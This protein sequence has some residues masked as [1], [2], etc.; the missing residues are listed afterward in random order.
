MNTYIWAF[1]KYQ[2]FADLTHNLNFI[3]P[4]SIFHCY[5]QVSILYGEVGLYQ[6][7]REQKQLIY[8]K[9]KKRNYPKL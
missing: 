6:G 5:E 9:I 4:F 8:L 1:L 7:L 3:K 2:R